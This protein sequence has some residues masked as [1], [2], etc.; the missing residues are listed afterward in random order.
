MLGTLGDDL[1]YFEWTGCVDTIEDL[2][3]ELDKFGYKIVPKISTD[4]G[5]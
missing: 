2:V 5:E 1:Y 4:K 3:R